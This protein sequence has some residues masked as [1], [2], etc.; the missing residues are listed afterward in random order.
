MSLTTINERL[1]TSLDEKRITIAQV[2]TDTGIPYNTLQ[3]T[4]AGKIKAMGVDKFA[5]I[6]QA[7]PSLDGWHI[8]T[9]QPSTDP[10]VEVE[11]KLK[12]VRAI[13]AP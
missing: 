7:Y 8:L 5:A 6:W 4:L 13:V 12:Q 2:H 9:G 3:Q 1:A 11:E 10:C